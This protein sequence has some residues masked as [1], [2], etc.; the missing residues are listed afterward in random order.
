M[1]RRK[2]NGMPTIQA[3]GI[4]I[5]YSLEGPQDGPVI[6][7]SNSLMS[8]YSMWDA[9]MDALTEKYRVLRY[10]TR[11]HGRTEVTPGPYSIELLVDDVYALHQALGI[12]KTHF[13]GLSMGGM[14]GQLLAV[15]YPDLPLSLTLCDTASHM[16]PES[17]WEDRINTARS[18]GMDGVVEGTLSRW[19]TPALHESDPKEIDRIGDMIRNTPVDGFCACCEAIKVMDQTS[20]LT[21]IKAP[22]MIIVGEEDAGTTPD[23]SR[24]IQAE[25]EGSELVILPRAAHLS[26]IEQAEAFNRTLLDFLSRV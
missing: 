14:T 17:V 5:N 20:I 3:N 21:A 26:N 23:M 4:D 18:E 6:S 9:Q 2:G 1:Y 8:N 7:L 15:K 16:P 10:D 22:T 19:F 24:V 12:S 11:G 25:I 13:V